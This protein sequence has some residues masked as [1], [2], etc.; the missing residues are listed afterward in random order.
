MAVKIHI[1]ALW[2]I[3][4]CTLVGVYYRYLGTL[5]HLSSGYKVWQKSNA[6]GN[7]VQEPT[8]LLPPPSHGSYVN[9]CHRLST[10]VN[11][12]QLLRDC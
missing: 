11:L 3:T 2:F 10:S 8:M 5:L 9:P 7:A 4:L 6:T 12:L 1:M